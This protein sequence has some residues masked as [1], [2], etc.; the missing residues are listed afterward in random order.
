MMG[1][2]AWALSIC[3][4]IIEVVLF[5]IICTDVQISNPNQSNVCDVVM[6]R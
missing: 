6:Y 4:N 5:Y 3:K 2:I 1:T